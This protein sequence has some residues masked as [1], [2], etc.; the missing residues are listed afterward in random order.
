MHRDSSKTLGHLLVDAAIRLGLCKVASDASAFLDS[1]ANTRNALLAAGLAAVQEFQGEMLIHGASFMSQEYGVTLSP[2]GTSDRC[3]RDREGDTAGNPT[4]YWLDSW[5]GGQPEE[6]IEFSL[7]GG[8]GGTAPVCHAKDVRH[9]LALN[10][11]V[12]GSPRMVAYQHRSAFDKALG[13]RQKPMLVVFPAPD[14]E[15]VL[16]WTQPCWYPDVFDINDRPYW[17][18]KHDLTVVLLIVAQ[19]QEA[20]PTAE[21]PSAL[22]ARAQAMRFMERSKELDALDRPPIVSGDLRAPKL[23]ARNATLVE[24]DGTEIAITA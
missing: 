14:A 17:P 4:R 2:D 10:A 16:T 6:E 18:V 9:D 1:S 3:V 5:A 21:G 12:T 13:E 24:F 15:Y 23:V 8:V 22:A 19:Y 11:G 20:G 7:S